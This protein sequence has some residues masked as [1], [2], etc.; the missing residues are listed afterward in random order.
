MTK[1]LVLDAQLSKDSYAVNNVGG[2]SVN[3]WARVE[4]TGYRLPATVATG[5]NFAAQMYQGPDGTYKIAFRGTASLTSLGDAAM[6]GSGIVAGNWTP[7][8]QQAM[9]FTTLAI[10]QVAK[11][12][13]IDFKDA[14]KLFTVTGHSQG[15]FEAE[16]VSKMFGLPGTSQDGPGAIAITGTAG[17]QAAKAAIQAQEPGAVLDGA[18]P[19]FLVRQYTLIVGGVNAHLEGVQVSASA[20]PLVLSVGLMRSGMGT[21]GSLTLQAAV[22]HK[23]DNI[24]AIEKA[25]EQYPWL[26]KVVQS[27]DAGDGASS[28]ASVVSD[29]WASVHVAGGGAGV[30]AN[31]VHGVLSDF[32]SNRAGQAISVQESEK[33]LYVQASNGDTLILMPDGSGVSTAVLGVQLTQK[34]YAKGGAWSKTVQAQRDDDGNLLVFSEGKGFSFMG[35]EDALGRMLQGTYKSFDSNGQLVSSSSTQVSYTQD[36][37]ATKVTETQYAQPRQ[38]GVI[39]SKV[40]ETSGGARIENHLRADGHLEEIT[41]GKDPA[42]GQIVRQSSK[43]LSYSASERTVASGEVALAGLDLM[44][45]LRAGNKLQAVASLARLVNNAQIAANQEPVLGAVGTGLSGAVSIL[46]ALDQWG[47]ASDGQRIALAARAVLGANDVARA[48]SADGKGFIEA[49][50]ALGALQGVIALASLKDV[51]ESGNPFAIAS[52]VMTLTNSAVAM[53]MLQ[54]VSM[55]LPQ[56]MIAVAICSVVFA[57]LFEVEYPDPPPAGTV[58]IGRLADG[59][60]GLLIKDEAGGQVHQTRRLDGQ[61]VSD[62]AKATDT[63]DWG[64][65]AQVLSQ[66]MGEVIGE[67]RAQ[68]QASG[69]HLVLERLP[70]L[71]V[72]AFPSFAGNGQTNFFFSLQFND[73]VSGAQQLLATAHQDLTQR[74]AQVAAYAG[75]LVGDTEWAQIGLKRAAGDAFATETEGQFVDRLSGPQEA[76]SLLTQAQADAQAAS[77]RQSYSLLTLDLEGDGLTRRELAQAGQSLDDVKADTTLGRARLDVDNDGYLELTEWVG[78]KEAILG[79]DRNG[80]GRLGDASELLTG[81]ELSDAAENLGLKR[82]AY[83]DANQDSKLDALDPYFKSFKLW[84]DINGDARSGVGEVYGLDEA[85]VRQIDLATGAVTFTDGQALTL[86]RTQLTAEAQGVA[87]SAVADGQGGVLPGQFTVQ[88]EGRDAE[89]NLTADAATDL[90]AILKLVRPNANLSAAD[91]AQLVALAQRYGVDLNDPAALLGL[92]G[93][94]NVAGSPTSTTAT[95]GDVFTVSEVPNA[96]EVKAALRAFFLQVVHNPNEGPA[97]DNRVWQASEDAQVRIKTADLLAGL[98]GVRLVGVQDARRG[99][100]GLDANGDVVFTPSAN[101]HGTGYFTYTAQDAEGRRSTAMVWLNIASVNDA[102]LAQADRFSVTEDQA[103]TL[104]VSQLLANDSDVD[105]ALDAGESLAVASV[106]ATKRGT[107]SLNNGQVVFRPEANYQGEAGFEYTVR[108]AAGVTATA[109]AT[110][111]VVGQND[112]PVSAGRTVKLAAR[113]DAL[114]RIEAD[115]LLAYAKDVDQPYGDSLR[116][117]RVVSVSA[118]SAWQQ[119]DG[120]VLFKAGGTGDVVLTLEI[121]DGQGATVRVPITV[122]V[123]AANSAAVPALP[124]LD[125]ATEDTAVR[126][127]STQAIVGV[128]G[129]SKGTAFLDRDGAV[130]FNPTLNQNGAAQVVYR[131]RNADN[132]VSEKTVDFTIAAVNDAPVVVQPLAVQSVNEDVPLRIAA[133]T[134]LGSVSD[135]DVATNGQVLRLW[136]VGEAVNGA[137]ALDA[138]GD[139]VF[140]PSKD[141]NGTARFTYWVAD[142]AGASVAV[143]ATVAVRPV[144]DAPAP[145]ARQFALFEDETR[146]LRAT[147]LIGSPQATDPDTQTNGDTLRVT[148]VRMVGANASRGSVALDAAGNV[149][150]TPAP[151]WSGQ[152]AFEFEVSDQAGAKGRN[153]A[154]LNLAPVN[155]APVAINPIQALSAGIEDTAKAIPVADLLRNIRDVDGDALVLKSVTNSVGGSVKIE[156]GQV[157]F[158]PAKDFNGTASFAYTVADPSGAQVNATATVAFAAVNDAPVAAYK[159]ID[160]RAVEDAELRIGFDELLKGAYDADG[161]A[162]NLQAVKGLGGASA[163]IDWT[164]RQVVFKGAANANGT[165][166]F[167]YTLADPSGATGTQKVDVQV[168]AVNDNPTVRAI[169]GFN[170]WEDGFDAANNQDPNASRAVRLTNFLKTVGAADVDSTKLSFGEFSGASHITSVTREGNDVV[171]KLERQYSGAASFNYRVRDDAGGWADGQV[172]LNVMA[173]NDAP[174]IAGGVTWN[175]IQPMVRYPRRPPVALGP[176]F[177]RAKIYLKDVDTPQDQLILYS[178]STPIHGQPLA[179]SPGMP[180]EMWFDM[181]VSQWLSSSASAGSMWTVVYRSTYGDSY[182]GNVSV[183]LSVSDQ[184]GGVSTN[185]STVTHHGSSQSRGG[186]PVAIDL[187][188]DGIA[189]SQLGDSQ[190]LFDINGDG[191]RDLLAWTAAE[192]GV[193]AFDKD[194]DGQIRDFDEVSFLAYLAGAKTDLE[195]LAGFDTNHDGNLTAADARWQQFGVWQDANQDGVSDPGEFKSLDAWGIRSLDLRSDQTMDQVGD[196]FV[197]GK[198]SFEWADGRQGEVADVAFRYLDGADTSITNE[199]KTYVLDVEAL[200]EQRLV[201]AQAEGATDTELAA[202][203]QRFID[204]L[205]QVGRQEVCLDGETD[206]QWVDVAT[207]GAS[208]TDELDRLVHS[209]A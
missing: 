139:V 187:N 53:G 64:L 77:N 29:R 98:A 63:L 19:D 174:W 134:L 131:V 201:A 118:G 198:S 44:Q 202:M 148:A 69:G 155:D 183:Q 149:V 144:N 16:L 197:M 156:N 137:V 152:T 73:P 128:V 113:P 47:D 33:A 114:L 27:D 57:S 97:L 8:M 52:T 18:M 127:T 108:D 147:D 67:L 154:T 203:L 130:V 163:S 109:V 146:T 176:E 123:S 205:T 6:N 55:F 72:H 49:G 66:R 91:R 106:R 170:T 175:S 209:A 15:G 35:T 51:L 39:E 103:L 21:L 143:Q 36:G 56:T 20:V 61:V 153:T 41:F 1:N 169:T 90:S 30:S 105:A 133:T 196:V 60:L 171:L 162:L 4:V 85:G 117:K 99:T 115:T 102:P 184:H 150:F 43:V 104:A 46:S 23:L 32:L 164:A 125:Q 107:V 200:L 37:Q 166:S 87:V 121:A 86:Q 110:V 192:D 83:F 182:N 54:G 188:G 93:G 12:R 14:A 80:D 31:E 95:A 78:S 207:V 42:T 124:S 181:R 119:K 158:T 172:A 74:Y 84:L 157:I 190:V 136:R 151:D 206:A 3:G 26:Q 10:Q 65:G 111:M 142:D 2:G 126:I 58:E 165:A 173:Q 145:V 82:L 141:F 48:I 120:S 59:T 204:E 180:R 161:D 193:V 9:E 138:N 101:Q 167:E 28:L 13:G 177:E 89:L 38:D 22:F 24:I 186:K 75:A 79:I 132:S 45:A 92:G 94:G 76:D 168:A 194:G 71:S 81:G 11:A 40:L 178:G 34:E 160:G 50:A 5:S 189:Y 112:A 135:V 116:L 140:T 62:S 179:I 159:R 122:N 7:E 195:G 88:V 25:R 17:Y 208:P 96:E 129:A 100:V 185:T 70:A 199:P 191:V 68:A